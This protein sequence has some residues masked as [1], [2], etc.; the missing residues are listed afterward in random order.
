MPPAYVAHLLPEKKDDADKLSA[1][2]AFMHAAET[3]SF[4]RAER[5]GLPASAVAT[6]I[7]RLEESCRLA[8]FIA[9]CE[10]LRSR[11]KTTFSLRA[12]CGFVEGSS[13]SRSVL[14]IGLRTLGE[15][16]AQGSRSQVPSSHR[17]F[18]SSCPSSQ[19][20]SLTSSSARTARE[21]SC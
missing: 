6:A 9:V 14:L 13:R 3:R 10:A 12:V 5:I 7:A 20:S 1:L 8:L 17:Y 18:E 2:N 19:R 16:Y 21:A 15:S 11:T 4:T